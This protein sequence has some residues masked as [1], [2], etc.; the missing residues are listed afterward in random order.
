MMNDRF[1]A[2]LRQHLVETANE[3]PAEGQTAAVVAQVAV[4]R[5]RRPLVSRLPGIAV[6]IESFPAAVRWGLI[7]VALALAAMAGAILA[8]GT[9]LRPSTVFEGTWT[10]IDPLD[11]SRQ[12]L[13]VGPGDTP[14][15]RYEDEVSTGG[16]CVDDEVKHFIA[17][18][19]GEITG[20]RLDVSFPDGGG[21][22]R[23]TVSIPALYYVRDPGPDTLVDY[24]ANT[25]SPDPEVV[26]RHMSAVWSRVTVAPVA[27]T[28][29]P[30]DTLATDPPP[31][32]PIPT[33]PTAEPPAVASAPPTPA[34]TPSEPPPPECIDLTQGGTYTAPAGLLP[35]PANPLSVTATI[36]AAPAIPWQGGPDV[37]Y[38]SGECESVAPITFFASTAT[39]VLATSCMPDSLEITSFADAVARLDTP[40]G[41]DISDRVD[42]T[43]GGHAAARYDIADLRTCPQG[44]GLWHGTTLGRGETGSVYVIDV[45]GVLLAIEL[46]RDGTQTPAELEEAWAIIASLLIASV[47]R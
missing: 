42:L 5:Q 18:G 20:S 22:G 19:S 28:S 25:P 44:F 29:R 36:P 9:Q 31:A 39:D 46:N 24:V 6:R 3:R 13:F 7:A 4:T 26:A 15:V 47:E 27:P 37:F 32:E 21:C 14:E 10:S 45:D 11:G 35:A 17:L 33:L 40:T 8:G 30:P 34:A 2:Q 38:L 1:S 43:I 23:V 12:W 41:D 16:A